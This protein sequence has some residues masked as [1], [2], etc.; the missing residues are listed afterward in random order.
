MSTR[1]GFTLLEV[2]VTLAI[3]A[4]FLVKLGGII[5]GSIGQAGYA[6]EERIGAMLASQKIGQILGAKD[7]DVESHSGTFD[8]YPGYDWSFEHS[9]KSLKITKPPDNKEEEQGQ[10]QEVV[11]RVR[12]P[13]REKPIQIVAHKPIEPQQQSPAQGQGQGK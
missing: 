4:F 1:R 10:F 3:M 12:I 5:Q 2:V 13:G 11:L 7:L 8:G 6:R 9:N